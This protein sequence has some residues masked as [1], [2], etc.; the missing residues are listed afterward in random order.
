[1]DFLQPRTKTTKRA[2]AE[3]FNLIFFVE[4]RVYSI[5]NDVTL[6][7]FKTKSADLIYIFLVR[8]RDFR[9]VTSEL[10]FYFSSSWC[11]AA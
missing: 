2:N 10:N 5:F 6:N 11:I 8:G 7:N 1:M 4:C 9:E 3:L